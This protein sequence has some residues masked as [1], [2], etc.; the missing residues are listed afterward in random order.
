MP[1]SNTYPVY[2]RQQLS[3]AIKGRVW[4]MSY[5]RCWYCGVHLNPF[6]NFVVEHIVPLCRG[7]A[8]AFENMAPACC[9]CNQSK[10]TKLLGEWRPQFAD[11]QGLGPDPQFW[12]FWFEVPHDERLQ[13]WFQLGERVWRLSSEIDS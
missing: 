3:R 8:D 2:Q 6:R 5:G 1:Q 9:Y 12:Q 11:E 13:Y 10:G 7:G 4:A